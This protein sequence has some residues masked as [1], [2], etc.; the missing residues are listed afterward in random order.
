MENIEE[1]SKASIWIFRIIVIFLVLALGGFAYWSILIH[2]D[3]QIVSQVSCDPS[4]ESCFVT[5]CDPAEDD[6]CPT[7]EN[8]RTTYYKIINKNA[9]TIYVC[10]QTEEKLGCGEELS[11]L[12]NEPKC[13]YTFCDPENLADGESCS[14]AISV[15]ISDTEIP[16]LT[17]SSTSE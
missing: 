16:D 5:T 9:H 3:Y 8:E 1:K 17:S 11:C 6:T 7:V 2:R 14:T 12:E 15:P 13:F 10:E 4:I